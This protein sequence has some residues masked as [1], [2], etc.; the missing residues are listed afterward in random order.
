MYIQYIS[1]DIHL[2]NNLT[3]SFNGLI[4]IFTYHLFH[5][6]SYSMPDASILNAEIDTKKAK[7]S[8]LPTSSKLM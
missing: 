2:L 6:Y 3:N 4:Q 1:F 5:I 8:L 7:I